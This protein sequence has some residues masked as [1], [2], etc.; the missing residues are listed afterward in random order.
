MEISRIE[1][2]RFLNK[3]RDLKSFLSHKIT[4][5]QGRSAS[6]YLARDNSIGLVKIG[7][8]KENLKEVLEKENLELMMYIPIHKELCIEALKEIQSVFEDEH[9][10]DDYYNLSEYENEERII[11]WILENVGISKDGHFLPF[12]ELDAEYIIESMP[13]HRDPH[14]LLLELRGFKHV[15]DLS[16]FPNFQDKFIIRMFKTKIE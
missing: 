7:S 12:K 1:V 10:K 2:I 11:N 5:E 13:S 3:N 8:T 14:R 9:S 16:V 15:R 4:N 6:V